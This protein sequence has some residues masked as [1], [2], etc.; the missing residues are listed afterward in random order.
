MNLPNIARRLWTYDRRFLRSKPFPHEDK[1]FQSQCYALLFFNLKTR[2]Y[3]QMPIF[4][5]FVVACVLESSES[6]EWLLNL[7]L[8][9][10]RF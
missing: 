9:L 3:L 7:T 1:P 6:L 8:F 4:D 2:E 10:R 5:F